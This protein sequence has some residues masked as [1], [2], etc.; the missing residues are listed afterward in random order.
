[1]KKRLYLITLLASMAVL[2][3][4]SC[5]K[6]PRY[7]TF[8]NVQALVELP[9]AAANGL[10]NLTPEALPITATPQ[11]IQLVVNIASPAPLN[12]SVTVKLAIQQSAVDA[13][14]TANGTS[15]TILPAADY[16]VSSLTVTIPAGK[17]EA[18]VP[19]QVNTSLVDPS[20]QF[21]LP[22]TITD[23]GGVQISNYNTILLNVEAKNQYDGT[24]SIKGYVHRDADLTLGG[25][26]AAGLTD[27]L[28]T[29]GATSVTFTQI[30][31]TGSTAGGINPVYLTVDPA[32]N[33]VTASSLVN[34]T[35][36]NLPGY[37]SHY[38]PTT[39]TFYVGILWNGADPNHRSAIDTMT[40]QGPR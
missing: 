15:Y 29:A 7:Y 19:I 14:N 39:Q 32:T 10:G 31:A 23:G 1:M 22:F 13:Y 36:G 20:G 40:Y 21:I 30:W 16:T 8:A 27:V 12:K 26:I 6:D 38:D 5:L 37:N 9:L 35:L 3:L 2:N 18:I 11:T 4:S 24:Y 34:G 28:A 33:L 25:P 17:R